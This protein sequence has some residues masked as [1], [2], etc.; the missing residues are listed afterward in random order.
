[1]GSQREGEHPARAFGATGGG[2]AEGEAKPDEFEQEKRVGSF[3]TGEEDEKKFPEDERLGSFARGQEATDSP[4]DAAE[5]TFG[6]REEPA[7]DE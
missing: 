5:G 1:M 2:F 4:Q 3:A 7:T 6:V